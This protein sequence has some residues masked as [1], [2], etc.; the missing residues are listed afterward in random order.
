MLGRCR[1]DLRPSEDSNITLG[2]TKR[3][4]WI[5]D[6]PPIIF[7]VI[8]FCMVNLS[9]APPPTD[10]WARFTAAGSV[11]APLKDMDEKTIHQSS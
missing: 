2:L 4:F 7:Q 9:L 1:Q 6:P 8:S 10:A 5:R 3:R 11:R